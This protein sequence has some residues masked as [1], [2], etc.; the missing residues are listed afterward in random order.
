MVDIKA[1]LTRKVGPL[2]VWGWLVAGGAVFLIVK[3][4]HPAGASS[5]ATDTTGSAPDSVASGGSGSLG[6]SPIDYTTSGDGAEVSGFGAV[7]TGAGVVTAPTDGGP[8][9][10]PVPSSVL[11]GPRPA[12]GVWHVIPGGCP[13]GFH[14]SNGKCAPGRYCPPGYTWRPWLGR[15]GANA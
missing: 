1:T 4:L 14:M 12:T 5:T 3:R 13:P 2:P 6:G 9:P 10:Q 11:A 15:C 8:G 7:D